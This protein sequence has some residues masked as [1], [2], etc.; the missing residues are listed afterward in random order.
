MS[1]T[2]R[3]RPIQTPVE[4]TTPGIH[5]TLLAP[6]DRYHYEL[7]S[8]M[9]YQDNCT[10]NLAAALAEQGLQPAETPSPWNLFMNLPVTKRH[11]TTGNLLWDCQ[12][13]I[14][15]SSGS[16]GTGRTEIL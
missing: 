7:L 8:C 3:R 11:Q 15:W 6:C 16:L 13:A 12:V 2:N 5:D 1:C 9:E 4:S 10:D 14:P